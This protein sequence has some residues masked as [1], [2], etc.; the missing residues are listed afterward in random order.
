[1]N[2]SWR[3][4]CDSQRES[5]EQ[6]P[7][8][9]AP[10]LRLA[11]KETDMSVAT[12][13]TDVQIERDVRKELQWDPRVDSTEVKVQ[14][15]R[16]VVTLSGTIGSYAKKLAAK[17]AAHRVAGVLDVVN[18]LLIDLPE[19]LKRKDQDIA[20]T[21]R[22]ALEWD[23]LVPEERLHSTVSQGWVTIEGEVDTPSQREDAEAAIERLAGVRGVN[24]QIVVNSRVRPSAETIRGAI[25][26]ALNRQVHREAN[27]I[28]IGVN[29]GVVTVTG[30]LRSWAEKNAVLN[31]VQF[32]PGVERLKDELVVD[33]FR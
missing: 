25:A 15:D 4:C 1:M 28:H 32:A 9:D 7:E 30:T 31:V 13:K 23:V 6:K 19:S 2:N 26:E 17:S 22:Q 29:D 21:I 24:N 5:R 10:D 14:V 18:D 20:R 16:G 11:R 33:S 3:G 27:R 8:I 12:L